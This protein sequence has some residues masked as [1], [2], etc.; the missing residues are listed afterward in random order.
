MSRSAILL[1]IRPQYAEKI[2][3]RS[4]TVELRRIRPK[5]LKKGTLV[6]LYVS[7]PIKSLVGA[8]KVERVVE[9]PLDELWQLVRSKAGVTCE[10]FEAYYGGVNRGVGIFISETWRLSEPIELEDLREQIL[11]FHP[12]QGFRYATL[13]ELVS[14]Q[15]AELVEDA[16]IVLQNSFWDEK[17]E[18]I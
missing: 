3:N 13:E 10:E 15:L 7:S 11:N 4:K 16:E 12:P 14:P 17:A 2:F 6:L 1:S 8:F 18:Q 9:M 5:H